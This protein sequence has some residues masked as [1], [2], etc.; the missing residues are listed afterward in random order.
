MTLGYLLQL[1]AN[2]LVLGAFYALLA[3]GLSLIFGV[4]EIVNFAHGEFYMLGAVAAMLAINQLHLGYWTTIVTVTLAGAC[5]GWLF[6]RTLLG[7]LAGR[8]FER[9]LLLTLGLGMVLQNGA[10]YIFT[11]TPQIV[12][13]PFALSS[14]LLGDVRLTW[15]RLFALV[16]AAVGLG[17]LYLLLYRTRVGQAM[18]AVAENREAALIVGI[19]PERVARL[20][21]M[22]G[23]A[24]C[25]LSGAALAP[26][27]VVTPTM[28]LIFAFKSFAIVV[29]G[30]FGSIG[31]AALAAV[32]L[33]VIEA[34]VGG[35]MSIVLADAVAFVAMIL[36]LLFRPL[37]LFGTGVRV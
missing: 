23:I 10:L 35:T 37:G 18:R 34:L 20:A 33:G 36:V 1:I 4:L 24:L 8:S 5:V 25:F 7:G 11:A 32:S 15:V 12:R 29:I 19:R 31:G 21:V 17:G 27:Y 3:M 26:V 2:G 13:T 28:G 9:S 14:V 30:G 16:W 22:V 6:H